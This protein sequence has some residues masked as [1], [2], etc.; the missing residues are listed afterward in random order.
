MPVPRVVWHRCN[1]WKSLSIRATS[2]SSTA[3]LAVK[4]GGRK[5]PVW[6]F[7]VGPYA[8]FLVVLLVVPVT[9]LALFSIHP[10]SPTKI[11]LPELTLDNYRKLFDQIG[12]A[13]V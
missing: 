12:R 4:S 13:H 8:L 9:N 5:R 10:Y 1:R 6:A 7:L 2:G 11:L 3:E